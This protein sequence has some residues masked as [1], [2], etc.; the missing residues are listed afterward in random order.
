VPV[1]LGID[2][3]TRV[4]G[5][6][7]LQTDGKKFRAV[8]FGALD[9]H[10]VNPFSLRLRRI[11][12]G[13]DEVISRFSPD[14]A[15]FETAFAGRNPATSIKIGEGRG[16]ALVCAANH[17]LAVCEYSP[18]EVKKAVT[19]RGGAPKE[20]VQEMVRRMLDLKETPK[21]DDAADALAI[22][23]C[24]ANRLLYG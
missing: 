7:I 2:P 20:Q 3:G 23:I 16:V 9:V 4:V 12:E 15:V 5:W 18:R 6:A 13:I 14:E 22:A 1:I 19:G 10:K 17:G 8:D 24:R 21:P 11:Y